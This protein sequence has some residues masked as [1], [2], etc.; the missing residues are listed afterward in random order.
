[1]KGCKHVAVVVVSPFPGVL[2][3]KLPAETLTRVSKLNVW[4]MPSLWESDDAR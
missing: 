3:G 1:M 2:A 4:V